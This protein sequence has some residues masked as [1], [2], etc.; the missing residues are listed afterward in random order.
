MIK[1]LLKYIKQEGEGQNE[2]IGAKIRH[3]ID[4]SFGNLI[5][6]KM[7]KD[8]ILYEKGELLKSVE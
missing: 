2:N 6:K 4:K 7:N 5:A 3:K 8:I 1:I